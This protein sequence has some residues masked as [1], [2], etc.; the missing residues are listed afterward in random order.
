MALKK[1]NIYLN[2]ESKEIYLLKL[3][4]TLSALDEYP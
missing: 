3:D 1:N 4:T 2:E